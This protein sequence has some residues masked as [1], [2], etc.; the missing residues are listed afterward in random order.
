MMHIHSRNNQQLSF[1]MKALWQENDKISLH[2]R[3]VKT[4]PTLFP[5]L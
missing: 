2:I 5:L 3:I 1:A 4:L